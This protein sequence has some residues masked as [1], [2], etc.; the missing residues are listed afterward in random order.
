MATTYAYRVKDKDGKVRK[1]EMEGSSSDKVANALR[2]QGFQPIAIEEKKSGG[3]RLRGQ[4]PRHHG[5]DRVQGCGDLQPS[6]RHH[7]QCRSLPPP[8]PE[9]SRGADRQ[10]ALAK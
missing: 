10:P 6:V 5:P 2:G 1:G 9:H 4:D 7:D 8:L 3:L